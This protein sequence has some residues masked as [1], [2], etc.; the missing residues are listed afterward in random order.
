MRHLHRANVAADRFED[1][2]WSGGSLD[3]L[4]DREGTNPN[5]PMASVFAA[6]MS[7]W[8]R[9]IQA[10][11]AD[12]N[13]SRVCWRVDR[14]MTVAIGREMERLAHWM[15]VLSALRAAAPFIGFA[16]GLAVIAALNRSDMPAIDEALFA[17][18]VAL[19]VTFAATL[20]Y[21]AVSASLDRF[22]GRLAGFASEFVVVL[23]RQ[24]D[25]GA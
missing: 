13:H 9:S 6:A 25:P 15:F 17:T 2:F 7:E 20:A 24:G 21:D 8:R 18:T 3:E 5:N 4:F 10:A 12:V 1:V 11:S 19:V 16:I 14:L 23:S 22:A